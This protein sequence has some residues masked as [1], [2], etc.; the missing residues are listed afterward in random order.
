MSPS[1]LGVQWAGG[2]VDPQGSHWLSWAFGDPIIWSP[3]DLMDSFLLDPTEGPRDE[4]GV[5]VARD[6]ETIA[7]PAKIYKVVD[8]H[9]LLTKYFYSGG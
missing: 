9:H 6:P 4:L 8:V 2:L 3:V 5:C 7:A 1:W